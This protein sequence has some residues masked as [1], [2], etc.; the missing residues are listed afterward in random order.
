MDMNRLKSSDP[1][2]HRGVGAAIAQLA[3]GDRDAIQERVT[4]LALVNVYITP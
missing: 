4:Q 2:I 1:E 3:M